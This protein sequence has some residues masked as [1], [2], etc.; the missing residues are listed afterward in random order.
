MSDR[1]LGKTTRIVD[2]C[3]QEFFENGETYV[4]ERTDSGENCENLTEHVSSVFFK[5]MDSEHRGTK[6]KHKLTN[7]DGILCYHVKKVD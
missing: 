5:R 6:Y 2:R 1:K 4:Y 7:K 3:I